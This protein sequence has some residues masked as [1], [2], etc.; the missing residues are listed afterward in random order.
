LNDIDFKFENKLFKLF[1]ATPAIFE[2]GWLP[3]WIKEENLEGE[4]NG[5]KL[6]LIGCSIGKFNLIGG[7]NIVKEE[8]KPMHK[9]APAGSVYYFEILDDSPPEAIK[10]AFHFRNISDINSEEGFGLSLIGEVKK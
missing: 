7:W 1:L 9:A 5:I 8:P 3:Y 10:E 6:R 4:F 2:N